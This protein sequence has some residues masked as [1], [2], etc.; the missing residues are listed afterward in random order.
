[1][2][3]T[4]G[5][6]KKMWILYVV[7]GLVMLFAAFFIAEIIFR[8]YMRNRSFGAAEIDTTA[9]QGTMELFYEADGT[10]V[11]VKRR[12][13]GSL[14]D[15]FKVLSSTDFH[16]R[17][18]DLSDFTLE[19]FGKFLD[20]EKPDLVVLV[21]DN[22]VDR[23][24]TVIHEKLKKFFEDRG[25]Y[26]AFVL[27]NHDGE[28]YAE[29]YPDRDSRKWAYEA[30]AGSPHCLSHCEDAGY[31]YG[32][33]VVLLKNSKGKIAQAVF[34]LDSD[35]YMTEESCAEIGKPYVKGCAFL[36]P[37]Q[38]EWYKNR[39]RELTAQNGG[40]VPKSIMY[41]HIP[42]HEFE[43]AYG[44][45]KNP[46]V[47]RLYGDAWEKVDCSCYSTGMFD[48]VKES[49]STQA[50]ICGHD[51]INCFCV[52]YDGIKLLYSQGLQWD[53]SYNRRKNNKFMAAWYALDKKACFYVEGVT[54]AMIREDGT[55]EFMPKYAQF[56]G[57]LEGKAKELEI[58]SYGVKGTEPR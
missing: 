57:M 10:P 52:E 28:G 51:H 50:V 48:A 32:N 31:G 1:M 3:K 44:D 34:L 22:V 33:G 8:E 56:E 2:S 41:F 37:C 5:R 9:S 40:E 6:R 24:D 38:V 36:R 17:S 46:R 16:L 7:I 21:G 45:L 58:V 35:Q 14:C 29:K 15:D 13:D 53:M 12:A 49:G 20:K 30:L 19:V 47:K 18:D 4:G 54:I 11:L 25:Q 27:G 26:W 55:A 43:E 42:L 39:I 23:T